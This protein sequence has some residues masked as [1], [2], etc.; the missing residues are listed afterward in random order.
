MAP[1]SV[2]NPPASD[3]Q[4]AKADSES[5]EIATQSFESEAFATDGL[6]ASE[7]SRAKNQRSI[8]K[9]DVAEITSQLA[10]M[11]K[12]G[13]DIASALSSLSVQCQRPAL[14]EIL[15][16]VRDSVLAG[17]SFS[18]ALNRHRE[19]FG[20]SFVAT[21][22]AGEASGRMAEVLQ[23][24]AQMQRNEIKST[25]AIRS[26]MIYP[27]LL[28]LVS[29]SVVAAL[30]LFVLPRFTDLFSQYEMTLPVLTQI[31]ISLAD[32]LWV[33]WWLWLPMAGSTIV[34]FLTWRTTESGRLYIDRLW[35]HGPVV[36]EVCQ[37][38]LIGR[39][40]RL[41]GLMLRNGVSLLESLKLTR[42]A[43]NNTIYKQLLIDLEEAVV[44]GSNMTSVLQTTQAMPPSASEM[45]ITAE[46]TGNLSEVTELLGEYY[47][48]E[49]Q[50]KA[51][52]LVGMLE[53]MITVGMGVL[54][55]AVVLAV[56]LPV[57]D[58]STL[59]GK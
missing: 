37:T 26:V 48:E 20:P 2:A 54:I 59:A 28:L 5:S 1:T 55:A 40:C 18:E 56:M 38:L 42:Q 52:G 16:E 3:Q 10:I 13:V 51:Q 8:R 45:L 19:V 14:A 41:L 46:S 25:R 31:L 22:A 57:F 50:A 44:N 53:P 29:G 23:Q 27:M 39:T 24:L 11:T 47:E 15:F 32:E 34:G 6:H 58:L 21:V 36:G 7:G 33:R 35:I 30:V 9:Q 17:V 4:T 43:I 12:S 49:A